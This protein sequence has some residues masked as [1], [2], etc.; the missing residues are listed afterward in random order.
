MSN[1]N[2]AKISIIEGDSIEIVKGQHTE[3]VGKMTYSSS[4]KLIATAENG[5][6]FGD[7]PEDPPKREGRIIDIVMFVAGTTDPGNTDGKKHHANTTYWKYIDEKT[8]KETEQS[9]NNLWNNI[10]KL[11]PKFLDLHIEGEFFSWSGDNDTKERTYASERLFDLLLRVYSGWKNQEV[12]LHLIGHS[13][14]GNVINQF[15]ELISSKEMIAKSTILK[16]RKITEFPK[17]WKVKS[18]TYLSTPFF[19]KKH[20]LNHGKLHKECK[21]INVHN[22]YDLTQQLVANF[23][24]NNLEGLLKSFKMERFGKGIN[25]VKDVDTDAITKYLKSFIWQDFK[26]KAT[27]A[28]QEMSKA[29]LGF[30]II[31]AEFIKYINSLKI[32]NSNL[33]KEKDSFVSLLN[34]LQQWTYDV[35]KNYTSISGGYD[36]ATWVKNMKLTQGLKVLNTLFAIKSAPKD[37]YLLSLLAGVFGESKGITDSIDETLW[38]P[39]KQTKGLTIVDV[40]IY[41]SDLYN[42]RNKKSAFATFLKGAQNAVHNRELEDML[43][44]LFSQFIKPPQLKKIISYVDNA[45][46]VVTGNLDT[47]LKVLRGNLEIYDSFVTKYYAGL[48]TPQDEKDIDDI[49]KRPG[50]LPY[51]A[52]ASHSLSHTQ[53][54]GKAE[55][56]LK[57]AFSSGKNPGYKKK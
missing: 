9:L 23:S 11:K 8:K 14:G 2:V 18:I 35:H 17:L 28:W 7:T 5:K 33:Q 31:T 37:S 44:R 56:G 55:E 40:P 26:N 38:S 24:L 42:S 12:H 53:L 20:Q 34:N 3:Y 39:K 32:E 16:P 1:D 13:H 48:V 30:N 29:F 50:T 19:Q 51:L 46:Y 57:S 52:M 15:T 6:L 41:D 21:I 54:W 43:M 36:K 25:I 10:K 45:E 22:D 27:L 47:E 49:L 4:K